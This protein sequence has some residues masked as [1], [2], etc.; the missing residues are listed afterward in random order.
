MYLRDMTVTAYCIY[1]CDYGVGFILTTHTK[2]K[3]CSVTSDHSFSVLI[4]M[5]LL[6]PRLIGVKLRIRESETMV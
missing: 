4:T 6:V 2:K 1:V 5:C 3:C